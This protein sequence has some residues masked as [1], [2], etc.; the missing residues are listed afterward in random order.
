[1]CVHCVILCVKYFDIRI[2]RCD[3]ILAPAVCR[4]ARAAPGSAPGDY[5]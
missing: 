2:S 5:A 1:M 3:L 4:A